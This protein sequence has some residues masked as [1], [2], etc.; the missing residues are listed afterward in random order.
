MTLQFFNVF[1]MHVTEFCLVSADDCMQQYHRC[2]HETQSTEQKQLIV[3]IWGKS[4]PPTRIGLTLFP[5][6]CFCD[7]YFNL[8]L[9]VS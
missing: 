5:M 6:G 8:V 9:H 3:I 2:M 4:I 1:Y 7:F